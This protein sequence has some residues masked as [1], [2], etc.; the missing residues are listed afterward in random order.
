[1]LT[2]L[3]SLAMADASCVWFAPRNTTLCVSA[4][5]SIIAFV[6]NPMPVTCKPVSAGLRLPF[7]LP[8]LI[9]AM[10]PSSMRPPCMPKSFLFPSSPSIAA[11]MAPIPVCRQSPSFMRSDT[12]RPISRAASS[13]FGGA[14]SGIAR[15]DSNIKSIFASVIRGAPA[16]AVI[17]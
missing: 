4:S 1:M 12:I 10:P 6:P 16:G 5:Q 13:I 3:G 14:I 9:N 17:A 11:G 7:I 8:A 2:K 15:S